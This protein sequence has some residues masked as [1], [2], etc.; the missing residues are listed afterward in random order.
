[1]ILGD[2]W[3]FLA[4]LGREVI[5]MDQLNLPVACSL[6]DAEF[7]E[8]RSRIFQEVGR[9]VLE[10]KETE[11]GYAYRFPSDDD[12]LSELVQLVCLERQCC[13]FLKFGVTVEPANGP[14]WLELTGPHGTKE[15]LASFL[16]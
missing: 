13:P 8:R 15:F 16:H 1:M 6:T 12:L 5:G 9:A 3:R 4:I 11:N 2:S 10:V 7:R 14:V